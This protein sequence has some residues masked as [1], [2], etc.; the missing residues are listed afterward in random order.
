VFNSKKVSQERVMGISFVDILIQAVF[1]L[2]L[3][4]MVGYVDPEEK[5]K[6]LLYEAAGKDLC[7]KLN[8]DSPQAC[9]EHVKDKNIEVVNHQPKPIDASEFCKK[10]QLSPE[11]CK[12]TLD[13]MADNVNLWPCIPPTSTSQ[14]T[15]SIYWIARAPGEIEFSR[16]SN[17]YIKYL[18]E[19]DFSDKLKKVDAI[20][21]SGKKIYSPSEVISTF[22]FIK[23]ELCFHEYGISRPGKFSDADLSRDFE[24]IR[25]LRGK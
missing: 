21:A 11:D 25:S 24:A 8:K 22:G 1:L 15:R 3:I 9:V 6:I 5:E 14:L 12:S 13:K 23:E 16:F 7:N 20:N 2:L 18:K 4:L 10:R 17:E 19:N